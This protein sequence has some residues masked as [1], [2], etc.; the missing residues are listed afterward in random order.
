MM[1][2]KGQ[3]VELDYVEAVRWYRHAA[4]R[5]Y[6]MAQN[7]LGVMY[8]QGQGVEKNYIEAYVWYELASISASY[9]PAIN[10][11]DKLVKIMA[12]E[13]IATAEELVAERFEQIYAL[14]VN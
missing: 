13:E 14:N 2:T 3:G 9:E 8:S 1:Y 4:E 7:N 5:G 12:P 6:H 10:N 11:R